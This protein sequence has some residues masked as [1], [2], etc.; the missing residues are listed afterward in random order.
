MKAFKKNKSEERRGAEKRPRPGDGVSVRWTGDGG[1]C[2]E[3]AM[4]AIGG[5]DDWAGHTEIKYYALQRA[6]GIAQRYYKHTKETRRKRRQKVVVQVQDASNEQQNKMA[7]SS[8]ARLGEQE[9]GQSP[10]MPISGSVGDAVG[11]CKH[12]QSQAT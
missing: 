6:C 2:C 10:A 11:L 12:L 5:D 3:L 8:L 4:V 1:R 9:H 7:A